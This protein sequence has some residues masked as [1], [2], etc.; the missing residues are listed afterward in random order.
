MTADR[1]DFIDEDDARRVLLALLEEVADA[2]RSYADEHLDEIG[3]AN[4]EEGHVRFAGNGAREQRLA[5]SGR[6]HQQD[7]LGNAPAEFLEFLRLL[8]ELDNLLELF[9]RFIDAGDVFERDLIL[10]TRRE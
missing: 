4:R 8:E 1:I 3:S 6:A 2:G 10:R 5:R 9:L 7:A